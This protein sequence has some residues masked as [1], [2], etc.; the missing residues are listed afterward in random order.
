MQK[1]EE[2]FAI[3]EC[4]PVSIYSSAVGILSPCSKQE[5]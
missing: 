5:A 1:G 2:T 4:S 3:T